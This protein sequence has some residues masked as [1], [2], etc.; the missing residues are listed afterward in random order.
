MKS[1]RTKNS[2]PTLVDPRPRSIA[3]VEEQICR[4]AHE[5]Y[6]QRGREEGHAL[7]DWLQAETEIAKGKAR[8]AVATS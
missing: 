2:L 8:T 6:E 4:R 1:T 5:L 7:D 3:D